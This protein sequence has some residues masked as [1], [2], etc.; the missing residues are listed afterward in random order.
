MEVIIDTS[1]GISWASKGND[2][3]IQ[4]IINL[5]NTRKYEVA[6]DRTLGLSGD[7]ID[8]PSD[9]AIAIITTE[10]SDLIS[11][12]EPR[13]ELIEVLN[14]GADADGNMKFRVVVDI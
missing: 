7:F 2:R 5:L 8:K 13:A 10:I 6:Y 1:Q 3:I 11:T 9:E 4:N 12:R 14:A